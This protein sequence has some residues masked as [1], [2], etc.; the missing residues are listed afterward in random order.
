MKIRNV[1]KGLEILAKYVGL[2]EDIGGAEHDILY[3]V[4][5]DVAVT[6]ED[7]AKLKAFGWRDDPQDGWSCFV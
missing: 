3:G 7:A 6:V 5:N 2:D 1:I 4:P